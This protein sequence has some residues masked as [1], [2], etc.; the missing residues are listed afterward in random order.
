MAT[1]KKWHTENSKN[2]E[3]WCYLGRCSSNVTVIGADSAPPILW[4][5]CH[6]S[7]CVCMW[8]G[9]CVC[10]LNRNDLKL[11]TVVV[12][13]IVSQPTDFGFKG[14]GSG[15]QGP[16][17][18]VFSDCCRTHN[19]EPLPLPIFIHADDN[20]L[21]RVHNWSVTWKNRIYWYISFS[22]H[23]SIVFCF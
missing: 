19:E 3:R 10:T 2:H 20:N 18:C 5:L 17:A 22:A 9:I 8:V 6:D 13:D 14:Q 21:H 23:H 4:S 15:A 7:V 12:L 16:L 11:G 1:C